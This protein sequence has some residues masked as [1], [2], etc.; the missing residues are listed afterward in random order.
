M[1]TDKKNLIFAPWIDDEKKR[2]KADRYFALERVEIE[3]EDGTKTKTDDIL[4]YVRRPDGERWVGGNLFLL[5]MPKCNIILLSGVDP[6]I[7]IEMDK[8][9]KYPGCINIRE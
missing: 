1:A 7:G 4:C 6:E 5:R 3:N 8:S 2:V 9:G